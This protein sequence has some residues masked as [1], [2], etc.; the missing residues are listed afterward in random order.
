MTAA[1]EDDLHEVACGLDGFDGDCVYSAV[2]EEYGMM[3]SSLEFID[4]TG[5]LMC[6]TCW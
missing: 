6:L 3:G 2:R 1:V 5:M 4:R